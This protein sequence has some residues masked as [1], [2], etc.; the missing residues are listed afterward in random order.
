[1]RRQSAK[2]LTIKV[3]VRGFF[4]NGSNPEVWQDVL[5]DPVLE[6]NATS[7]LILLSDEAYA[8][9][10]ER[11]RGALKNAERMGETLIFQNT[12]RIQMLT[13]WIQG[14]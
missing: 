7:Q 14:K 8:A 13:A 4:F 3:V 9:G 2:P 12:I 6:K 5:K 1:V 10:L 11:I